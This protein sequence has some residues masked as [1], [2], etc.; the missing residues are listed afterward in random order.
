MA[1]PKHFTNSASAPIGGLNVR[2]PIN[3]MPLIDAVD[4]VN[5]IPQQY[6]VR[7]RKGY[8]EHAIN[9][10]AEVRTIMAYKPDRSGGASNTKL[11]GVTDSAIYDVT[12]STNAPPVSLVLPGTTNYGRFSSA[13]F[14]N[15]AGTFLVCCSH[16]GGYKYYNGV[17]WTTPTFGGGAGQVGGVNPANLCF[18]ALWKRRLWFIEKGTANVWYAPT[19]SITGTFAKL[20]VGPL[21]KN[22]GSVS[23][24]ANWT[25]DAGEGIDDFLII[26]GENGD[27]LIYKGTDPASATTFG[28]Q[29]VYFVGALPVGRRGFSALGGDLL[30]LT[31]L[32][33]QPMSYV[34]RGGQSLLRASSSDYLGKVQPELAQLVSRSSQQIGWEITLC[35][36]DN[37]LVIQKPREGV[38]NYDQYALYTNTNGWCKFSNLPIECAAVA[39]NEF[40]FGTE[41]GKVCKG[42]TG[43]FDAVPYGSSVGNGIYGI[44]Q[45]AF[46]YFGNPGVNKQ[47]VMVRPTFLAS[48]EPGVRCEMLVDYADSSDASFPAPSGVSSGALWD[49]ALWDVAV[50]GGT[51]NVY[52]KWYT[53]MA[54]GYAGSLRIATT[55]LGDTFLG[56]IDYMMKPGGV[57]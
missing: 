35:P 11:F 31:E 29:G 56:S 14:A 48:D 41:D 37:L 28:L 47:W 20:D 30:V 15:S 23:F 2:D 54:L 7:T 19:D 44:I 8:Q 22:G 51:L 32:G 45:P 55:C 57:L 42:F 3:A 25:I 18:V 26:A 9:L 38:S 43:F 49:V 13:M 17:A 40:W 16:E 6:G 21:F 34:T 12:T 39:D 50:W 53:V 1:R 52:N 27:V 10:G 33:L 36:R 46:N 4:L 24:I 5:W